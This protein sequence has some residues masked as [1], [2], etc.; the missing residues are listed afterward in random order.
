MPPRWSSA[1]LEASEVEELAR[2]LADEISAFLSV[3][4]NWR[5]GGVSL[6]RE[7]DAALR[8]ALPVA[9]AMAALHRCAPA[10]RRQCSQVARAAALHACRAVRSRFGGRSVWIDTA[11]A[12]KRKA[13]ETII[14][15][16]LA[17]GRPLADAFEQAGVSRRTGYRIRD[18]VLSRRPR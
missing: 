5:A 2:M 18:R 12:A 13:A 11:A 4:E 3:P 9:E 16:A 7:R 8:L 10:D 14:A 6:P 1:A 15:T 17:E